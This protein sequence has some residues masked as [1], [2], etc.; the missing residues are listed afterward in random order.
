VE[1]VSVTNRKYKK[2][3]GGLFLLLPFYEM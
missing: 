3:K 2:G 1:L